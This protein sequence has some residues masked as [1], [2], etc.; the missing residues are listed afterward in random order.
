MSKKYGVIKTKRKK[1][2]HFMHFFI[3]MGLFVIVPPIGVF[4]PIVWIMASLETG[5]FN[6]NN[7]DKTI[8]WHD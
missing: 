7:P 3:L 6:R 4:Y 1:T 5:R 2:S 8:E